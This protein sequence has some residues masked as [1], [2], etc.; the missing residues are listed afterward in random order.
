MIGSPAAHL[1][2]YVSGKR[3]KDCLLIGLSLFI[4][5][6][7]SGQKV[8]LKKSDV[9]FAASVERYGKKLDQCTFMVTGTLTVSNKSSVDIDYSNKELFLVIENEGESR[10]YL[11]SLTS[12][13]IDVDSVKIRAGETNT[14][15]VYWALP[16]VKSLRAERIYLEWRQ[17]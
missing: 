16:P 12:H 15:H 13:Y 3:M 10:T 6:C 8:N 17:P 5:S 4:L 1:N 11:D 2:R 9:H 7:I 14:Y